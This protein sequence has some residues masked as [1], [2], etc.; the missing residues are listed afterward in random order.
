MLVPASAVILAGGRSSRMGRDKGALAFGGV[1]ILE[2][3]VRELGRHFEEIIIVAAPPERAQA[4]EPFAI[5]LPSGVTLLH[6]ETPYQGPV[7]ALARGLEHARHTIV[8]ACSWDLPLIKGKVARALCDMAFGYEAAIPEAG[9]RLQPLHA[10]Y[11]REA[12]VGALQAME[13]EGERRLTALALR[14]RIRR[15]SEAEIRPLDPE[16]LSL[17]NVNTPED[18]ARALR[19]VEGA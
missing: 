14:L 18:Y 10:A 8:F 9:G 17:L 19:H 7:G 2:R 13:A 12:A 15:V 16:L 5:C 11:G 4:S 3:I 1:T 6:D